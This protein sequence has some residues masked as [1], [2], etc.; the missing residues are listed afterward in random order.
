VTFDP[1]DA[2]GNPAAGAQLFVGHFQ[3][4][5]NPVA[6]T[7]ASTALGSTVNMVAGTYDFLVR[8]N[9]FGLR[10]VEDVVVSGTGA[11]SLTVSLPRNIASSAS[12][13]SA[14]GDGTRLAALIDDSEATNW[15]SAGSPIVGKQVTIDLAGTTSQQLGSVQVSAMIFAGQN[16]FTALRQFRIQ[17]CR[18]AGNRTCT[19][20]SQFTTVLTSP[21]NAFPAVQPRPRSPQLIIRSFP[22]SGSATHVRFIVLHNQCTGAPDYQGDQDDD[23][24]NVTDCSAGSAEDLTVRAAEVEVFGR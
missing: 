16:R 24:I 18:A 10:R 4:R 8:A 20:A 5:A 22:V 15:E 14:S 2:G 6:D 19:N 23:P 13:A 17:T 1:R 12:G 3:A 7:T 9:G 11:Q 21:A